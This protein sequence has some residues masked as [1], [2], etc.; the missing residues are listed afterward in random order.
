MNTTIS[1]FV[2]LHPKLIFLILEKESAKGTK[3]NEA[4]NLSY[5]QNLTFSSEISI[6]FKNSTIYFFFAGKTFSLEDVALTQ[7]LPFIDWKCFFDVWELRGKYPNGRFPKIFND[8]T[9]GSEAKR[10]YDEALEMLE[11]IVDQ[12]LLQIR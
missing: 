10:V 11:R 5:R 7:L 2:W 8:P 12:N 4:D 3:T 6:G 1:C 9:V